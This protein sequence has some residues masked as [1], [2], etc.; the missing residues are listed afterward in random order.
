MPEK[1]REV[2]PPRGAARLAFRL[3]IFLYRLGL[4]GLLGR[5]A[6]CLVHTGRRSGEP[7]R[8]VLEVVRYDPA[9]GIC[10]VAAGFGERSDWVRNVT[11]DP[12]ITF[13]VGRRTSPGLAERLDPHAAGIELAE[14]ARR[15][16]LA[17]R[18][19]AHVM[20]YRVDGTEQD[21]L[22]LGQFIPMFKVHPA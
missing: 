19:L 2:S 9:T 16:P 6:V 5:R 10:I 8:T 22:S 3:P 20:G 7:R 12:H 21:V 4:G 17:W 18:E 1:L 11:R 14:Y 15:H 13:T